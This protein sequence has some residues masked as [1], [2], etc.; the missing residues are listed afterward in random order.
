ML[1]LVRKGRDVYHNGTKLT[2]VEQKTKGPGNEVIKIEGLEGANGQK[3]VSLRSLQEGDNQVNTKGREVTAYQTYTLTM[4]EKQE[5]DLL[6][7]RI[8]KIKENA[9]K[10]YESQPKFK[11]VDKMNPTE[12]ETYIKYLKE[13]QVKGE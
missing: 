1:V 4:D 8:N 10:R 7:S 9:R 11:P 5:I 13:L 3:W 2:M 12:L 6:Q